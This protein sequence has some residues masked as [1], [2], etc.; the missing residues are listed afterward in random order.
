MW[1]GF[2]YPGSKIRFPQS[3]L[4]LTSIESAELERRLEALFSAQGAFVFGSKDFDLLVLLMAFGAMGAAAHS[5]AS[6]GVFLGYNKFASRWAVFYLTRPFIGAVLAMAFY[7]ALAAKIMTGSASADGANTPTF[8]MSNINVCCAIAMIVGLFSGEAMD[9]LKDLAA[10]LFKSNTYQGA[11][12][13]EDNPP[14]IMGC[15]VEG[16]LTKDSIIDFSA[17]ATRILKNL[18]D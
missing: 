6:I 16:K 4:P 10:G 8:D 7:F 17:L 11:D 13:L 1:K 14:R 15:T 18:P 9:K 12:A 2:W 3:V 5:L